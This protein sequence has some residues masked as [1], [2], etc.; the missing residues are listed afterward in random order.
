MKKLLI[1]LLM[2]TSITNVY[3]NSELDKGRCQYKQ[4][5]AQHHLLNRVDNLSDEQRAA[6]KSLRPAGKSMK[7]P[8]KIR[9][10]IRQLDASA[11]DYELQVNA[12]AEK[13][14]ERAKARVLEHAAI[15]AKIQNILTKEQFEQLKASKREHR[16]NSA[17]KSRTES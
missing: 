16:R 13:A 17:N 11:D 15:Q 9:H 3:A 12:I 5:N 8:E 10:M 1:V 6:L 2:S 14:A 4:G 7:R